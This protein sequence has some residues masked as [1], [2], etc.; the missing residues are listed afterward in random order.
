MKK[1][2]C[3][4]SEDTDKHGHPFSLTSVF[5]VL[6]TKVCDISYHDLHSEESD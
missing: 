6:L 3:A 2:T 5:A 4:P 1:N